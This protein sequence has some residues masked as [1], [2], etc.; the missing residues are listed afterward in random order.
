[1]KPNTQMNQRRS[2]GCIQQLL[3]TICVLPD[4]KVDFSGVRDPP[5]LSGHRSGKAIDE[6]ELISS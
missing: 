5:S 1:M 3:G 6:S 2:E 4:Q